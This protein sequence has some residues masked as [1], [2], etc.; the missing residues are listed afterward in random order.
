MWL[1][2][3]SKPCGFL[4][5]LYGTGGSMGHA[6]LFSPSS[7]H[8]PL[9]KSSWILRWTSVIASNIT[10]EHSFQFKNFIDC[11]LL[12]WCVQKCTKANFSLKRKFITGC[13]NRAAYIQ[14]PVSFKSFLQIGT[15][16]LTISKATNITFSSHNQMYCRLQSSAY[17]C[18]YIKRQ[19][20]IE[21]SK[22]PQSNN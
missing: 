5:P 11:T 13:W 7:Y 20:S 9:P 10:I 12:Q 18:M 21:L 8:Y 2:C 6:C 1:H 3:L 15:T 22:Y 16:V 14:L 17:I 4:P 19:T